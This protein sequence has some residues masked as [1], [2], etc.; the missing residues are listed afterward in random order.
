MSQVTYFG[1][2]GQYCNTCFPFPEKEFEEKRKMGEEE[3]QKWIEKYWT[4]MIRHFQFEKK[5]HNFN[6]YEQD[7]GEI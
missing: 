7:V 1:G 5:Y 2:I 4:D 6:I 3:L